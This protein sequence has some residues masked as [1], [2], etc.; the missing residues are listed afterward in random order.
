[1]EN[2]VHDYEGV[3][4]NYNDVI[5]RL[6]KEKNYWPTD[7]FLFL[8]YYRSIYYFNW[9]LVEWINIQSGSLDRSLFIKS[10]PFPNLRGLRL[11]NPNQIRIHLHRQTPLL[12]TLPTEPAT[13]LSLMTSIGHFLATIPQ[14][15]PMFLPTLLVFLLNQVRLELFGQNI[16]VATEEGE[17]VA[18][19]EG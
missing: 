1:M 15:T 7:H 3:I 12:I 14:A 13:N 19:G 10:E 17:E 2:I 5:E 6:V 4:R 18:V 16:E 11:T 9:S 8:I